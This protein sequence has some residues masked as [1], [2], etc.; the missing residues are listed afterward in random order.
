LWNLHE[1]AKIVVDR[2]S[3]PGGHDV[4]TLWRAI[5]RLRRAAAPRYSEA[6]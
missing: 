1:G 5:D 4:E 6:E 2:R 3:T